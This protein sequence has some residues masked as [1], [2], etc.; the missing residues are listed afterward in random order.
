MSME[1][2]EEEERPQGIMVSPMATVASIRHLI[3]QYS[4][5]LVSDKDYGEVEQGIEAQGAAG[6]ALQSTAFWNRVQSFHASAQSSSDWM[7]DKLD[8]RLSPLHLSRLGFRLV[9]LEESQSSHSMLECDVCHRRKLWSVPEVSGPLVEHR[10]ELERNYSIQFIQSLLQSHH[11]HCIFRSTSC[12]IDVYCI[13]ASSDRAEHREQLSVRWRSLL[14]YLDSSLVPRLSDSISS[15]KFLQDHP[16]LSKALAA[17]AE[18]SQSLSSFHSINGIS[19]PETGSRAGI[20]LVLALCGWSSP[21]GDIEMLANNNT[22]GSNK[23]RLFP[24]PV[25]SPSKKHSNASSTLIS[26]RWCR[27]LVDVS[28]FTD[29]AVSEHSV[30]DARRKLRKIDD[31]NTTI[32]TFEL[33]QSSK[34]TFDPVTQHRW[35]CPWASIPPSQGAE[36]TQQH[37]GFVLCCDALGVRPSLDVAEAAPSISTSSTTTRIIRSVHSSGLLK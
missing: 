13:P 35:Y 20:L 4:K 37:P 36:T 15:S 22:L 2:R 3:Q 34:S 32:A 18:S 9:P 10:L 26:C 19:P 14:D 33:S 5:P 28:L 21:I 6:G 30:D 12:A 23:H 31:N 1:G 27:R 8:A 11:E 29:S 7:R 16:D 17:L 25:L 24:R